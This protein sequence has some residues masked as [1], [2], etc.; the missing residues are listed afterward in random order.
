MSMLPSAL[1][2]HR[3][4]RVALLTGATLCLVCVGAGA[5]QPDSTTPRRI[6]ARVDSIPVQGGLYNRP[7]LA[8]MGRTAIGGYLEGNT[9]YFREA[10]V[11]D[12]FSMELRRFNIFLFS[13]IG[14]RIRFI[15]ELEFEDGAEE[16]A[17]ETALLDFIVNPSFVV[18]AGI[19]LPPVGAFNVNHD[20]P[21]WD[22]IDRPLVSTEIIPAT[23]SEVG[24]G[25]HGRL[26]PRGF[27]VTYDAYLTNG[28]GDAVILNDAGRTRLASGKGT[29]LVAE[30]NNG[31]PAL[32]ARVGVQRRN[33]GELGLSYYGGTYNT[34]RVDG[35]D[36]DIRRGVSLLALDLNTEVRSVSLRG[37]LALA[38]IDVPE[39]LRETFGDRQWGFHLDAVVPIFRPRIRGLAD[40]VV[41]AV[42]RVE[43][44]DYN[45]GR[46]ASTGDAIGD[47]IDAFTLGLSFRPVAGTV[48]KANYRHE[49][50]RDV[51]GNGP[52]ERA[53][54]QF[55]LATYF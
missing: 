47:E 38:W 20:S 26:F 21:R 27:S 30:D 5:Q 51:L 8:S 13:S 39:D 52:A 36:V 16:I 2:R 42:V 37:E 28:L 31:R 24:F 3:P 41:N 49:S 11:S 6:R 9:N 48:F 33:L 22:V 34:F 12:G 29:G 32:S 10:G 18:R 55:G 43:R 50:I 17:L 46:F 53:G 15:S 54:F 25:A 23:L 35:Q 40:P 45:Q 4:G 44:V 19:L 1:G 7:F 14:S